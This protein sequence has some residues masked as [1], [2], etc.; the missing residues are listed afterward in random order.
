MRCGPGPSPPGSL[1]ASFSLSLS[2]SFPVTACTTITCPKYRETFS[3]QIKPPTIMLY[4][5][6]CAGR[7]GLSSAPGW[8][9]LP[10]SPRCAAADRPAPESWS[11]WRCGRA[12]CGTS[13]RGTCRSQSRP[14]C[15]VARRNLKQKCEI[16]IQHFQNNKRFKYCPHIAFSEF[17]GIS[18]VNSV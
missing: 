4:R 10:E 2:L 5:G 14:H 7:G 16:Y 17:Y 6:W 1:A 18:W 12:A 8:R 11:L 9:G 3:I 13:S 15:T